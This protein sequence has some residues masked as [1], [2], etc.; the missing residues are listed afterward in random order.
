MEADDTGQ[1]RAVLA[2]DGDPTVRIVSCPS[3]GRD[4]ESVTGFVLRD[5]RA[6]A[7]YFADWHPETGEA[8]IDVVLG[9]FEEPGHLD[10]VTF[11]CRVGHVAAQEAP[12]CSLVTGGATR[13][14]RPLLGRRLDR[15]QAL[16]HPR[17]VD[18]WAVIDWLIVNDPTL[19]QHVFHMPPRSSPT[20]TEPP[21]P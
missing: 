3:C 21:G 12:A 6:H 17:L 18:F 16:G 11:G 4:H 13:S 5:G 19:H 2:F 8:F 7:V 9:A 1:A 15:Q 10:N 14:D 20:E